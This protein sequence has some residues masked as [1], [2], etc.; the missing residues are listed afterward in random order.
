MNKNITRDRAELKRTATYA[1]G[2]YNAQMEIEATED[3][4]EIDLG[5][6]I[7]WAWILRSLEVLQED[8]RYPA[9]KPH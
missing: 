8:G 2:E 1:D 5:V 7:P 6:V 4:L 3:G 9:S